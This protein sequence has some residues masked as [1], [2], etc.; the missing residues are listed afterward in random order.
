[1]VLLTGQEK[2][3]HFGGQHK[4]QNMPKSDRFGAGRGN[5][6]NLAQNPLTYYYYFEL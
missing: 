6:T 3:S 5:L 4:K 1:M 2:T